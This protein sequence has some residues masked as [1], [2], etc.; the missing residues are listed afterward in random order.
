MGTNFYL[1]SK[2]PQ[3]D[4]EHCGTKKVLKDK[5]H[6][7]KSSFGW[8][9]AL[10]YVPNLGLID[11]ASWSLFIESKPDYVIEDEYGRDVDLQS[12]K[13]TVCERPGELRY[14]DVDGVHCFALGDAT[15]DMIGGEFS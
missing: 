2:D 11:W 5:L 7:G 9:F 3:H 6:I 10:H 14:H 8:R 13:K 1:I 15:Y 12:L 4:C